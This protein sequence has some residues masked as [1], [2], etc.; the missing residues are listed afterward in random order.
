MH[1]IFFIRGIQAKVDFFKQRAQSSYFDWVRTNIK[2]GEEEHISLQGALRP[3]IWGAYEYVFPEESLTDVLAIMG[4]GTMFPVVSGAR[5]AL[6]R[7]MFPE[8][9]AI[10]KK[11]LKEAAKIENTMIKLQGTTRVLSDLKVE[12]VHIIPVGIKE[13]RREEWKDIGYTQEML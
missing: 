5:G 9:K 12:G 3:T 7:K 8:C 10:P 6:L 13:D 4:I 2:T 1:L 11:N